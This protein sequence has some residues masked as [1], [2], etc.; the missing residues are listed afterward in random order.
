MSTGFVWEER[1]AWHDVGAGAGPLR[2]GGWIQPGQP[3]AEHDE[4]K[5]RIRNLVEASGL[6]EDL[7]PVR[8]RAA[9]EDEL[10]R[11]HSARHIAQVCE[12]SAGEGG[13]IGLDAWV[14]RGS[15]EIAVLAAGGALAAVDAVLGGVVDNAYILSRPPGHHAEPDAAKGFCLFNNVALAAK[16]A[17]RQHGVERVAIVDWDVHHGNGAQWGFYDDPSVLTISLHQEGVFP[18]DSGAAAE[19]GTGAGEGKNINIPL[20]AGC[21]RDAYMYAFDRVVA[22]ALRAHAPELILVACGFDAGRFDPMGRMM[23]DSA[24]FAA[25]TRATLA[26][27]DALCDGRV[28][29]THE[30]GYHPG[31]VPFAGLAVLEALSD[32]RTPVEDPFAPPPEAEAGRPLL[33]H[34]RAA[35]DAVA[36]PA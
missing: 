17:Q 14:G 31:V 7:T 33:D 15:Y 28:V 30:G 16:H 36:S 2:A 5:R 8:A 23:L 10:L 20:P 22:P 13:P 4:T 6:L 12:L 3:H 11:F 29:M 18:P 34:Q 32:E 1:Y 27:A 21:G 35:V 24:D 25:L 26:L 19:R 9:S